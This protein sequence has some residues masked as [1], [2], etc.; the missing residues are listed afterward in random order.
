MGDPCVVYLGLDILENCVYVSL[1]FFGPFLYSAPDGGQESL[2][3]ITASL[4]VGLAS[5]CPLPV[6]READEGVV[7]W[8]MSVFVDGELKGVS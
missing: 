7:T 8:A 2:F 6:E 4:D 5:P 1:Q 3:V